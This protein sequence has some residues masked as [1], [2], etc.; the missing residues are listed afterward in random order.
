MRDDLE[1]AL[2]ARPDDTTLLVYADL[3]QAEGD[4][5]G[6]LIALDL[7]SS[8]MSMQSVENRRGQLLRSWLGDEIEVRWD[9]AAQL[10]YAGELGVAHATFD[11]GFVD[12]VVDDEIDDAML[13]HLLHGPAGDYLRRVSMSGPTELLE[14]LLAHL[15]SKR[16]P[17][18]QQLAVSRPYASST[19]VSPALAS[20]LV[21]ATP[22]LEVLDLLGRDLFD[23]FTHPTLREL[24]I[25]GCRSIDLLDGPALPALHTIDFA[26]DATELTPRQWFKPERVPALRRLCFPRAEPGGAQLFETLGTINVADQLTHLVLPSIRSVRD[27]ALVQAAI[28]RMPMLR[29]ISIARTYACHGPFGELRHTW[30]RVK[31][32]PA[33]PWPPSET[34]E[35]LLAIDG[36]STY[37]GAIVDTLEAQY[38]ELP[39]E[40]RDIWSRFWSVVDSLGASYAEQAFNAG[41]LAR[42]LGPLQLPP[43]LSALHDHLQNRLAQRPRGFHASL[44]WI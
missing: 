31:V 37:L 18:L 10:W 12:V 23:R 41:D 5:R 38:D 22:H 21:A 3:L 16:R 20:K 17:W 13:A 24:A 8:A 33:Y 14:V 25:T 4:P 11:C 42:A 30:A 7:R 43:S 2:H 15:V 35:R 29:E 9:A 1:A 40:L 44:R 19:L 28:D 6:E 34:F 32:P 36:Y 39:D 26:F 27:H